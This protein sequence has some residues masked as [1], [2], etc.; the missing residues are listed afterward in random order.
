MSDLLASFGLDAEI[1]SLLSDSVENPSE[2][3]VSDNTWITMNKEVP[4]KASVNGNPISTKVFLHP[5]ATLNRISVEKRARYRNNGS[6]LLVSGTMRNVKMD[7][8][9]LH[10]NEWISFIDFFKLISNNSQRAD[11]EMEIALR[12]MNVNIMEPQ[13]LMFQQFG[14]DETAYEDLIQ[15]LMQNGFHTTEVESKNVVSAYTSVNGIPVNAFQV[16]RM[17]RAESR[18]YGKKIAGTDKIYP[19]QGFSDFVDSQINKYIVSAQIGKETALLEK[20][21]VEQRTTL[22]E[23]EMAEISNKLDANRQMRSNIAQRGSGWSGIQREIEVDDL[24]QEVTE[25]NVFWSQRAP[26]GRFNLMI[27]N[28]DTPIS[29]WRDRTSNDASGTASQSKTTVSNPFEGIESPFE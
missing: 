16:G 10:D 13:T 19:G 17:N 21:R 1:T 4:Y 12:N 15:L 23:D 24:L 3:S 27:D 25:K 28:T 18:P 7:I 14:A 11:A 26:I 8:A 22:T 2:F 5:G 20:R 29:L 6:Y 9:I